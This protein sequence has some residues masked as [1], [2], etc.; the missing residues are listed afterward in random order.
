MPIF[1]H[2]IQGT[3]SLTYQPEAP[4]VLQR[5]IGEQQGLMKPWGDDPD[6][7]EFIPLGSI[8]NFENVK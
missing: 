2:D 3:M 5:H 6:W 8:P 7:Y 4:F 1:V